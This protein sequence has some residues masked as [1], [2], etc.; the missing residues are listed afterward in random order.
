[1]RSVIKASVALAILVGLMSVVLMITGL[2]RNPVVGGLGSIAVA[3][4]MN[5]GVVVWA[6]KKTAVE[7]SYR[8]QLVNGLLIGVIAGVLIFAISLIMLTA[9]PGY[10]DG[11][12]EG[13]LEFIRNS[14]LT[15]DQ[16]QA[17]IASIES[18]TALGQSLA[19]LVGTLVTSFVVGA[20]TAIFVRKK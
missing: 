4:L 2:S 15:A 14:G 1:M 20:I 19:G 7:N 18:S 16:V 13:N 11:I 17:R 12:K 8:K 9:V 6:L 10:F 5:I 3:I